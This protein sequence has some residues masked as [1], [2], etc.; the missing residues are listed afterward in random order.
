[1]TGRSIFAIALALASVPLSAANGDDPAPGAIGGAAGTGGYPAVAE[2]RA[3]APQYTIYRPGT[4]PDEAL[5][6]V[7][8]GNGAC[9]DNGLSAAHFLREVASHGYV[10]V[11]NGRARSERPASRSVQPIP[12]SAIPPPTRSAD[13]TSVAGLLAGIDWAQA[14]NSDPDSPFYGRIATDRIAVLGHSCGGLQAIAAGT[15]PRIDTVIALASGVY[16]RERDGRSGVDVG[17]DDLAR[18]QGPI[19]YIL[20]GEEDIAY[21]NGMDDFARI[22]HVPVLAASL[23]VGHGGTFSQF[24]GGDWARVSVHWLDWQLKNDANAGLWFI[25]ENCRLCTTFG[26][27]VVSKNMPETP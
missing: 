16:V 1:M 20:G 7:L 26:W 17:K 15:D 14:A 23:P 24:D 11:A 4:M 3:E 21:A 2:V 10:V 25:G 6:L 12:A 5:P 13:E 19:A 18:L 22:D 8:W 9:R 27:D